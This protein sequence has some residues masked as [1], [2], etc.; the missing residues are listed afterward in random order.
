MTFLKLPEIARSYDGRESCRGWLC[1]IGVNLA[2]RHRRGAG[3][4]NR[5][6]SLFGQTVADRSHLNPERLAGGQEEVAALGRA[7]DALSDKKRAA[8]LLVEIEGL[9]AEEAGQALS[10]P[11]AT[12]RTRLFHARR[13]LLAALE[14]EGVKR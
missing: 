3:R 8:F 4:F 11:P 5:M 14:R 12:V 1:G 7:L 6:L 2:I 10:V 9:T 13:E